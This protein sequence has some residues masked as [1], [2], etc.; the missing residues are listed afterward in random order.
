MLK[1]IEKRNY[2]KELEVNI[3]RCSMSIQQQAEGVPGD[4]QRQ[5]Y[6]L[7]KSRNFHCKL[8]RMS[9]FSL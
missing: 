5:I 8:V 7:S 4:F 2:L 1:F 6:P 9:Q 3:W